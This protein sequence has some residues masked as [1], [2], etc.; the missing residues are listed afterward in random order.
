MECPLCKATGSYVYRRKTKTPEWRCQGCTQEWD[1]PYIDGH[2]EPSLERTLEGGCP[3]CGARG[4]NKPLRIPPERW[5][6]SRT[7]MTGGQDD[8]YP[9][10]N[11][12]GCMVCGHEWAI[13]DHQGHTNY[14]LTGSRYTHRGQIGIPRSSMYDLAEQMDI[15]SG[16]T[17]EEVVT[18]LIFFGVLIGGFVGLLVGIGYIVQAS[19]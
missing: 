18:T 6:T 19:T 4:F 8:P 17:F 14:L 16:V 3:E 9:E 10:D 11:Y 1:D 7:G 2:V 5:P 12:K 13:S 15:K